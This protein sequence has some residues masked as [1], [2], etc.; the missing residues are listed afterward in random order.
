M[1]MKVLGNAQVV[2]YL[3]SYQL[4]VGIVLYSL[5]RLLAFGCLLFLFCFL[6]Q[7]KCLLIKENILLLYNHVLVVWSFTG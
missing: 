3:E 2:E 6:N 5:A 4:Y 1:A 7:T